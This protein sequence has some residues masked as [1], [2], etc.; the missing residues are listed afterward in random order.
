MS[1]VRGQ[2]FIQTPMEAYLLRVGKDP[3]VGSRMRRRLTNSASRTL[4]CKM[5][6]VIDDV[7]SLVVLTAL[8]AND[9][10][11]PMEAS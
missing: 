2:N 6:G 3:G 9:Q 10:S 11:I 4:A 1:L 5:E 7:Q 8:Q